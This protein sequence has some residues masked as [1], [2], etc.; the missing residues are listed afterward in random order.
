MK[1][2][3][4]LKSFLK[5]LSSR[6]R[7]EQERLYQLVHS[8]EVSYYLRDTQSQLEIG[9]TLQA[10]PYPFH[11]V[12]KYYEA[13]YL[14]RNNQYEKARTI[15]ENV[16]E[17]APSRYRS[18]ALL[19][20]SA[21]E[22]TLGNFEDALKLRIASCSLDDPLTYIEAQRGI[23]VL[24]SFEG[25]HRQAIKHLENLLPMVKSVSKSVPALY[26][27]HLNSLAI[28]L[29][30]IGRMEEARGISNILLASPY[31]ER[32]PEIG[33]TVREIY[34]KSQPASRSLVS[35]NGI[36]QNV[37]ALP[38]PENRVVQSLPT[39][40]A[41]VFSYLDWKNKMVKEPNSETEDIKDMDEK[42]LFLKLVQ[43][44]TEDNITRK[45]LFK[46]VENA[47]KVVSEP[48]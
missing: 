13:V 29:S 24:K 37:I 42:D 36:F 6:L 5:I 7:V 46:I 41:K 27:M 35:F 16:V 19:S 12:G 21:V 17:Y 4:T 28:E 43:I 22:E 26:P 45:K 44:A 34:L 31:S 38:I 47:I 40:P 2:T 18:K 9:L 14:Y 25:S 20:L 33:Q 48:D 39:K 23:A 11:Q 30:E 10:F 3:A 15:L 32:F 8:A 1:R